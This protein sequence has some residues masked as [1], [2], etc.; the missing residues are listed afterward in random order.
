[1]TAPDVVIHDLE[2]DWL[3]L[4]DAVTS[5]RYMDETRRGLLTDQFAHSGKSLVFFSAF[6]DRDIFS[7]FAA[8]IA[9][10]TGVWIASEPGHMIHY[11][12]RRFL[13][14]RLKLAAPHQVDESPLRAP[15]H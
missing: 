14:P 2:R 4:V 3:F 6:A 5:D 8:F 9:W 10:E 11:N 12:G 13:G 15:N 7:R 1:V